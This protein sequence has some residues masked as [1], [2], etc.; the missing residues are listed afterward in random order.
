MIELATLEPNYGYHRQRQKERQLIIRCN[1]NLALERWP[2][3]SFTMNVKSIY[4]A[5]WNIGR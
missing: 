5:N 4:G 2:K 3:V 1:L